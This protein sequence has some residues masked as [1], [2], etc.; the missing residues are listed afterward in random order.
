MVTNAHAIIVV[1]L[2]IESESTLELQIRVA[3]SVEY[4]TTNMVPTQE[5][6]RRIKKILITK[7]LM[8]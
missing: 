7:N 2:Y 6:V 3:P 4:V 1:P 8:V 5:A